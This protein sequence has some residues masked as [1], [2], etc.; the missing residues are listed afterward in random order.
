MAENNSVILEALGSFVRQRRHDLGLTQTQLAERLGWVQERISAMEHGRY[1][2]PSLP[3]LTRLAG[4]LESSLGDVLRSVGYDDVASS[5]EQQV[6]EE[7]ADA[8]VL[9]YTL[10]EL[11]RIDAIELKD[12]LGRATDLLIRATGADKIDAFIYDPASQTLVALGTSHT[13]M[14]IHQRNIGLDR[15]PIANGG[16]AVEVFET[17]KSYHTGRADQDPGVLMG[18]KNGLCVRSIMAVPLHVNSDRQGVLMAASAQP[19]HFSENDCLFFEAVA[20]WVGMVAHRAELAE[21]VT[22]EAAHSARRMAA[23]ELIT[24][25]AHD[26][27]NYLT[28]LKGRIDVVRQRACRQERERDVHDLDEAARSIGRLHQLVSQLLDTGRL[29]QGIFALSLQLADLVPLIHQVATNLSSNRTQVILRVPD[30]LVLQADA[31]RL[32][33]ALENLVSNAIKYSPEGAP[34]VMTLL[35]QQSQNGPRALITVRD[36]GPGIASELLPSLFNRFVAGS[37]SRG[38]GLGL[39]LARSIVEAHGGTLEVE[40]EAGRGSTFTLSLPMG[41]GVQP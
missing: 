35:E 11:L 30:E 13:P 32:C 41:D 40:S 17:G 33:Q 22:R 4:A 6:S 31:G 16:R 10:Q 20:R 2:M 3:A 23:D 15:M 8:S 25:L 5:T 37:G 18:I 26:L 21:R 36:E 14:G 9:L 34:V 29:D 12:A 19:D 27:G 1:G 38:L 24:L 7:P 39:Y 28:P